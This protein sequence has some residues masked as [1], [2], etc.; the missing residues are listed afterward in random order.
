[1]DFLEEFRQTTREQLREVVAYRDHMDWKPGVGAITRAK[2]ICID[3]KVGGWGQRELDA[4][5][6]SVRHHGKLGMSQGS[7]ITLAACCMAAAVAIDALKGGLTVA[8]YTKLTEPWWATEVMAWLK[9]ASQ[10]VVVTPVAL[11]KI[12]YTED[13]RTI[14]HIGSQRIQIEATS[15]V[16]A[17][18]SD[19]VGDEDANQSPDDDEDATDAELDAREEALESLPWEEQPIK[20]PLKLVFNFGEKK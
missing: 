11:P 15:L 17:P 2:G 3:A 18:Y 5:N 20:P 19:A 10:V 7:L 12:E 13:G 6:A 9:E 1:M 14:A 4:W 8:D 16:T